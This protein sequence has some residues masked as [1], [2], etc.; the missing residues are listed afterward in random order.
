MKETRNISS[1]DA[2]RLTKYKMHKNIKYSIKNHSAEIESFPQKRK[3]F[4]KFDK[5]KTAQTN[6]CKRYGKILGHRKLNAQ[7]KLYLLQMQENRTL[8]SRMS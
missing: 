2:I 7:Q 5:D 6:K 1:A 3:S 4:Q 8:G